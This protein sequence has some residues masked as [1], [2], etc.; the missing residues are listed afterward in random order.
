MTVGWIGAQIALGLHYWPIS[1]LR[2]ALILVLVIYLAN[3]F[4]GLLIGR[5]DLRRKAIELLAVGAIGLAA[6]VI[7]A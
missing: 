1:P 5:D 7:F 6:I 2:D 4:I 3:N